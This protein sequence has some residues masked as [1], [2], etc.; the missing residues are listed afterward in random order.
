M[1]KLWQKIKHWYWWKF[2][3]T[4][5]EKVYWQSICYGFGVMKEDKFVDIRAFYKYFY[6]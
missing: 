6:E 1:K 2:K 5:Q 4:D 3:A